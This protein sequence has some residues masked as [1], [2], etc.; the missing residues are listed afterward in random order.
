MTDGEPGDN[1]D[2]IVAQWAREMPELDTRSMAT[3]GRILRVSRFLEREVDRELA[4]FGL[5][6]SEFN[7]LAA[8]R[9]AG[10]P[11]QLA[12]AELSRTLMLSSG[13]L[14]KRVDRLQHAGLVHRSPDPEDGRGLLVGLTT[15]GNE[16]LIVSLTAHLQNEER[17]LAPLSQE[18]QEQLAGLLRVL[19]L[20]Y[21]DG[22][23]N[24]RGRAYR[25]ERR[26]PTAANEP[27]TAASV[28]DTSSAPLL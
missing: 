22:N 13:G 3:I 18:Q 27:S 8:L 5:N 21:G 2:R 7:V 9:R 6:Q 16:M 15:A 26:I 28:P 25:R 20:A 12:P 11:Y 1:L 10:E 23:Q 4:R 17:A 19:L 14:T 24:H